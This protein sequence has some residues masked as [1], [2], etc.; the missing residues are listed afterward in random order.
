MKNTLSLA[1]A[2]IVVAVAAPSLADD[3]PQP[4]VQGVFQSVPREFVLWRGSQSVVTLA[5]MG[6]RPDAPKSFTTM[7]AIVDQDR[8]KADGVAVSKDVGA[9]FVVTVVRL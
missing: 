8:A 4:P 1:L 6:P 7:N 5:P 3:T 2:A 9:G